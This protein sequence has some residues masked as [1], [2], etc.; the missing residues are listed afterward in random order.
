MRKTNKNYNIIKLNGLNVSSFIS[1]CVKNNMSL[2]MISKYDNCIE[3]GIND[4]DLKVL[5]KLDTSRYDWVLKKR[6]G[7]P[8]VLSILTY[9]IGLIIGLIFALTLMIF[10]NNRLLKIHI[11]GLSYVDESEVV[12]SI[13]E[14]G[15]NTF[16]SLNID[17]EDLENYLSDKFH[18][19]I[20][21]VTTKGCSL[22][23][24]VK[25]KLPSIE[26]SYVPITANYNMI[27]NS[28]DV[29]KG[30]ALVGVGDIVYKGD[31][32][33]EPYIKSGE[34]ILYVQPMATISATIFF[35]SNYIFKE[36][37]I[38][39]VR[40]G[41]YTLISN[42]VYLGKYK[43]LSKEDVCDYMDYE[44][45]EENLNISQYFLPILMK[46]TYAYELEEKTIYRNFDEEKETIV[47]DVKKS[48]YMQVPSY[49]ID[50]K[51][52]VVI[53]NIAGGCIVNVYLEYNYTFHY[54]NN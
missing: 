9:R 4:K 12:D 26:D 41:K 13:H 3:F 38:V 20:V 54:N 31:T 34:D 7:F 29:H 33:V 25:E 52:E 27:I 2:H 8:L 15:L 24:V 30:T 42:D 5:R 32:L 10:L 21:S 51:E 40:T 46:K 14:Y 50:G 43:L 35:S 36:E 49:L 45:E 17:R 53:T 6:G 16:S 37:E 47:T 48:A 11:D 18:F 44:I 22:I 28:I 23:V 1:L 39:D 19:S